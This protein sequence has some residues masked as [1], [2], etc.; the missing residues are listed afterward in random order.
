MS[1]EALGTFHTKAA[2]AHRTDTKVVPDQ[3]QARTVTVLPEHRG[4]AGARS[5]PTCHQTRTG[6]GGAGAPDEHPADTGPVTILASKNRNARVGFRVEDETLEAL[7]DFA[8]EAGYRPADVL[9]TA[10]MEFLQRQH[11]R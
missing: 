5:A 1:L 3:R 10:V 11:G 6:N 2:E 4:A 7:E 8:I 9:K